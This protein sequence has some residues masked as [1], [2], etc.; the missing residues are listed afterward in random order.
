MKNI[1][2][3]LFLI[4]TIKLYSQEKTDSIFYNRVDYSIINSI[5]EMFDLALFSN[6]P[7]SGDMNVARRMN[8]QIFFQDEDIMKN[9]KFYSSATSGFYTYSKNGYSFFQNNDPLYVNAS[10]HLG[11][12]YGWEKFD[13]FVEASGI[14]LSNVSQFNP[15]ERFDI[16]RGV[17]WE[18]AAGAA[19]KVS[20]KSS[21]FIKSSIGF[22]GFTPIGN[23]N[24][25][26]MKMK[27]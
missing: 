27:F 16:K 22:D 9:F 8:E 11:E 15:T 1:A 3:L 21:I 4:L 25:G 24:V 7:L 10:W 12:T 20:P 19:Y 5:P 14:L 2:L 23:R 26:G 6:Y 17:A 13:L 18:V